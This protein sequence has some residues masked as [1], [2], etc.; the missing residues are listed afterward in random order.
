MSAAVC[1]AFLLLLVISQAAVAVTKNVTLLWFAPFHSI[2]GYSSE[3]ISFIKSFDTLYDDSN[4]KLVIFHHGDTAN[5]DYLQLLDEKDRYIL[6]KYGNNEAS[7]NCNDNNGIKCL[8]IAICHSEPGAW[9]APYPYYHTSR[10]PPTVA[11]YTIG[12]T[13]FETDSIPRGWVTRLNFMNEIWVP[14]DFMRNVLIEE[15]VNIDKIRVIG[16]P[17]D[18]DFFVPTISNTSHQTEIEA[19]GTVLA[20]S[21][22][23]N[24]Y[25]TQLHNLK[26][27]NTFIYLF[28]GKFE[29]R[30]GIKILIQAFFEEFS[31]LDNV[32]LVILTNS[33]H[34]TDNF[35][36]EL[37]K[38]VKKY[39][40][41]DELMLTGKL[42]VLSQLQQSL[43]PSLYSICDVLVLPTH[44]EGWGR[45]N[46]EA[47]ACKTPVIST[48]WSGATAYMTDMNSYPLQYDS[49][50]PSSGWEG[51]KWASPS[52]SD[53]KRLLRH[54]L[55]NPDEVT[56]KGG[57]ARR[58]MVNKYSLEVFGKLLVAEIDTIV[59]EHVQVKS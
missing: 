51:H 58:D 35:K 17:V 25:L 59:K 39:G 24:Q 6:R 50:I 33:Y 16:E 55:Q 56:V 54:T 4:I 31:L 45:P 11:D 12:R 52:L 43:M 47:M 29:E 9:H 7:L 23:S 8:T 40:L 19:S 28:V 14:T 1:A 32:A 2:G 30:K 5:D 49:L 34:S 13:M 26:I 37:H 15:G 22:H 20:I 53:L 44:G 27:N 41:N 57:I 21:P 36:Y 46:V 48:N 18:T 38:L 42:I 3:A 10:C